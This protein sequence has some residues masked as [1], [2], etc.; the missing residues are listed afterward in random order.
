VEP[1]IP[2]LLNNPY[3]LE[4][5]LKTYGDNYYYEDKKQLPAALYGRDL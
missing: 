1:F 3:D 5:K 4:I 2:L